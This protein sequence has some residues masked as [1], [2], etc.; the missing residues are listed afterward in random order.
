LNLDNLF[1]PHAGEKGALFGFDPWMP[2]KKGRFLALTPGCWWKIG[3]L[4]A[5][6]PL[7]S[8]LR[9]DIFNFSNQFSNFQQ[10]AGKKEGN[11]I[12]GTPGFSIFFAIV[13]YW[14]NP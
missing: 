12:C 9:E 8:I 3:T 14:S 6:T 4:L 10:F 7:L 11:I 5:L 1:S 13:V 2:G